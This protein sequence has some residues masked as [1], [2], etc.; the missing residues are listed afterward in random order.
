MMFNQDFSELFTDLDASSFP[1][2]R[3]IDGLESFAQH[4]SA[5]LAASH[6]Q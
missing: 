6:V 5:S 1:R 4:I 3:V 2:D